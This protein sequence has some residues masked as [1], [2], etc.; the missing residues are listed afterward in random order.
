MIICL[1][2]GL[3]GKT[4]KKLL[5]LDADVIIDL[6]TLGLFERII[7]NYEVHVTKTVLGEAAYFKSSGERTRVHIRNRVK[8]MH[9]PLKLIICSGENDQGIGRFT[10]SFM[11]IAFN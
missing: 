8:V 1:P 11:P 4:M 9:I 3:L 6:H 5:L 2:P 7:K 10:N